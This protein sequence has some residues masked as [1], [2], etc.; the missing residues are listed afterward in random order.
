MIGDPEALRLAL[1]APNRAVA[2]DGQFERAIGGPR[3]GKRLQEIEGPLALADPTEKEDPARRPRA[4]G[5]RRTPAA[6][7]P[8]S[9]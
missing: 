7:S 9:R 2:A 3:R 8:L 1:S 4:D 5:R 6:R